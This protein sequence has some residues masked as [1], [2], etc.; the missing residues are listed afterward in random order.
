MQFF[1]SNWYELYMINVKFEGHQ[2]GWDDSPV[3][4]S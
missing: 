4:Y 1:I 2:P 3:C